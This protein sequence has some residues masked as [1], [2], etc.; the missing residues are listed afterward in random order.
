MAG[1]TQ[2]ALDNRST[3][4]NKSPIARGNAVNLT[5]IISENTKTVE[6][7]ANGELLG[8]IYT[9]PNLTTDTDFVLTIYDFDDTVLYTSAALADNKVT[10]PI[11][12]AIAVA[13][14]VYL[15]GQHKMKVA[16]TTAQ[17][18][19]IKIVPIVR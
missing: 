3:A 11:F 13:T 16:F 8:F 9:C 17:V 10:P 14:P 12:V 18:A 1:I 5:T 2:E 4:N 7:H 15:F 6:F 19:T